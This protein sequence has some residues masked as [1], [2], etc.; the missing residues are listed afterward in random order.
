MANEFNQGDNA[1]IIVSNFK[2]EEVKVLKV[3]AGFATI[4]F[5]NR[6]GGT[7]LNEHRLFRT[8]EEAAASVHRRVL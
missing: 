3:A 4:H 6:E 8:K 5:V 2:I 7:R 1:F